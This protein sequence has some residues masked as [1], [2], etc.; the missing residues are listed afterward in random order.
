MP[1][2]QEEV[3]EMQMRIIM[4]R[5]TDLIDGTFYYCRRISRIPIVLVSEIPEGVNRI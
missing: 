4:I 1:F 3:E 2:V 5:S